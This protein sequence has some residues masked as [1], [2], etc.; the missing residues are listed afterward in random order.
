[1]YEPEERPIALTFRDLIEAMCVHGFL[2]AGVHWPDMRRAHQNA[3]KILQTSHPFATRRFLTDGHSVLLK[4]GEKS[5]LD[6]VSD[7]YALLNL[8]RPYLK[9][10][11]L[12]FEGEF[13]ARWWPM[14]KRE[15]VVL[16]CSRGF[17]QP[18]VKEGVPTLILY[19]ACSAEERA[20]H[21]Q[22]TGSITR[23]A[24]ATARP[25]EQTIRYVADWYSV[26]A[27]SVRA[28]VEYEMRL[29]A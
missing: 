5:L 23:P 26:S 29:A 28:A 15:P 9:T 20:K 10:D 7:Q 16:D 6:L 4:V 17:G 12:E 24:P 8:L 18:I 22:V 3:A 14:G 2:K 1:M 19:R 25:V 21:R 13:V 11:G 27:R